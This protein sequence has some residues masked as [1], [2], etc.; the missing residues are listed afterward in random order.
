M[1]RAQDSWS[2]P[3]SQTN[4]IGRKRVDYSVFDYGSTIPL[5]F[6]REFLKIA[7][8]EHLSK[9]ENKE[10]ILVIDNQKYKAKIRSINSKQKR[11]DVLQLRYD[12]NKKLKE[13]LRDTFE[14]SYDYITKYKQA[15]E[16][17]N[18]SKIDEE[19][20]EFIDFYIGES[21]NTIV[22][23][24]I[25]RSHVDDSNDE[26]VECHED[27]D[28]SE[29]LSEDPQEYEIPQN[30]QAAIDQIHSYIAQKG[31]T[32]DLNLI[33]NIYLCLKTKP[34]LILTGISGTGKSKIIELFAEAIGATYEN[35][36]FNLIPVRPDWSDA[37]D[38]LGY[39]NIESKFTPG[40]ITTIAYEAMKNPE[41][42]YFIC[43]DEMNLARVEYYFS[44]I[45]SLIETRKRNEDGNI[46]T[47][48]L[49][50]REHFS[51]DFNAFYSYGDVYIPENLYIVGTVNMDETTFP[52]SKKV[53]DRANT[54]EFNEVNLSFDFDM[55]FNEHNE[56]KLYHNDFLKASFIKLIDCKGEKEVANKVIEN[57]SAINKILEKYDSHFA[58]RV[59]DEIVFYVVYGVSN[60]ILTFE[61]CM[62]YAIVQ[63]VL[64]KINGSSVDVQTLLMEL[65]NEINPNNKM[66]I[67][68]YIEERQLNKFMEYSEK[69]SYKLS[70]KKILYMIRRFVRDGFTTFW[71]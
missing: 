56:P 50:S 66:P 21:E 33:K 69:S 70:S 65:Y 24:L 17:K 46:V 29:E 68:D 62:D 7:Q 63:K 45:L 6:H 30:T 67:A 40:S 26:D 12:G 57:L 39:R 3:I 35:G 49:L 51:K 10:V 34:F 37:T 32:Y 48:K 42:P 27:E 25:D 5:R 60:D 2:T 19:F 71:R 61:E 20:Q 59:R 14:I 28:P 1:A 18:P 23:K 55:D 52:F 44:D 9:G 36:G 41:K 54:I 58:Y 47:E 4:Y 13:L 43:L 31:F 22:M 11:S 8:V 64:P 16:N 53:L 38:L 15:N